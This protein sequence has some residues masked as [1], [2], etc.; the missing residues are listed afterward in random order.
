[1]IWI[2]ALFISQCFATPTK[3]TVV[4]E[5][6]LGYT[7][8]NGTGTYCDIVKA[9]YGQDYQ[10][11]LITTTWSR[12]LNLV[13]TGRADILV[14]GYH[15]TNHKL[16]FPQY[17]LDTEYPLYVIYDDKAHNITQI[18]DLAGLT[19]AGRKDYG[20][21]KFLPQSSYFYGL[22]LIDDSAKFIEKNRVDAVL[23]YKVNLALA[24]PETRY[25]HQVIGKEARLYLAFSRTALGHK[26]KEHYDR[27]I[28][29]LVKLKQL[30]QYF[31]NPQEY[32]HADF[33]KIVSEN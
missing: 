3:L 30:Q 25:T 27:N 5:E 6:W 20:L 21:A 26:L 23:T 12:A 1:M 22:D 7:N 15:S 10:L 18:E 11:E 2:S 4:S 19:V 14:G 24:D 17:H 28:K 16:V 33:D 13:E 32:L 29:Q 8:A 9:V 31:P